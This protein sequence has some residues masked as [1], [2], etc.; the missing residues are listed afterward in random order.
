LVSG[1]SDGGT[2]KAIEYAHYTPTHMAYVKEKKYTNTLTNGRKNAMAFVTQ[3]GVAV[4]TI[5]VQYI[6]L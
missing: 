6:F 2:E 1:S 3:H 4:Y 5:C